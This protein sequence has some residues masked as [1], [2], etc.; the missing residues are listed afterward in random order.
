M[1]KLSLS[2]L[3]PL[4]DSLT[5]LPVNLDTTKQSPIKE[6]TK[7]NSTSL[8]NS[9]ISSINT[10]HSDSL[11]KNKKI[12]HD[13]LIHE[14]SLSDSTKTD[15]IQ[16]VENKTD[17]LKQFKLKEPIN[18]FHINNSFDSF[19]YKHEKVFI[20]KYDRSKNFEKNIYFTPHYV[21]RSQL[22]WTLFIGLI[23]VILILSIKTYYQ[24]FLNQVLSTTINFHLVDKLFHE[25]NILLRRAFFLLN[26]NFVL[27]FSLFLFL[28]SITYN[29]E[30]SKN[31]FLDYLIILSFFITFL[32]IRYLFFYIS[33]L[34]FNKQVV[35]SEYLHNKYLINKNIG[36]IFIPLVFTS[37]Y[38]SSNISKILLTCACVLIVIASLIKIF[39]GFQII[40]RNGV[41]LFYTILYLCTLEL[42]PLVLGSKIIIS[43]R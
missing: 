2:Y 10:L 33:G 39:R 30:I 11:I 38:T 37:I 9:K 42:L 5:Q 26:I 41:L 24:K 15:S 19:D 28:I 3:L 22:N 12:Y 34:L 36:I 21:Q 32:I 1:T 13:L 20:E 17:S 16:S 40:M 27:I 7:D 4:Q 25:K 14:T 23:S 31:K 18:V 43:L 6:T 29:I 8:K 35:I